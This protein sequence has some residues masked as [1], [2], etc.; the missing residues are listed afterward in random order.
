MLLTSEPQNSS[1]CDDLSVLAGTPAE[2]DRFGALLAGFLEPGDAVMLSGPMGAGK[3]HLARAVIRALLDDPDAVVPSPTYTIANVYDAGEREIWHA[4]LYRLAGA[5][6]LAE[7]GLEDAA[8][9]AVLLVEWPERWPDRPA[10]RLDVTLDVR[11][12]EQ[13]L[14]R[15]APLGDGWKKLSAAVRA[16]A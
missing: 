14:I 4:D 11:Q 15:I 5:D 3:S 1:S 10:R 8:R 2:T 16:L 7:I 12:A 13:R 6:E 9:R